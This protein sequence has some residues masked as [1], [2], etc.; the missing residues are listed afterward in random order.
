[1]VDESTRGDTKNFVVCFM[2]RDIKQNMPITTIVDLKDMNK[3]DA[4]SVSESVIETCDN[5]NIDVKKCMVWL[6][7]NMA[8]LSEHLNGAIVEFNNPTEAKSLSIG[9]G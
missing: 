3:C 1:M 7:A 4:E 9:Y 5:H 2:Y 8:Y 6:T